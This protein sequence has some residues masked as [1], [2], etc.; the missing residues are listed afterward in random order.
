[1]VHVTRIAVDC[2]FAGTQTGLGRYSRELVSALLRRKDE[3][4]YI[5]LVHSSDEP[6]IAELPQQVETISVPAPHYSLREQWEIP[7]AIRLAQADLFF[8]LHFNVPFFCPV[9]FI[10][11]VHDLILHRYPNKASMAKKAAYRVLMARAVRQARRIISVSAFTRSELRHFYG[12]RMAAKTVVIHEGVSPLF[13]RASDADI[14]R[15]RRTYDLA[16][17]FL[18]YVGNAKQH[19]NVQML[20][21]AFEEVRNQKAEVRRELVLVTGGRER[22]GVRLAD[23]VRVIEKVAD[24]DLP[25]LY[26]AADAFVTASLYEGFGL[27]V[28]EAERC[29][30]PVIAAKRGSIPEVASP[31]ATLLEPTAQAFAAAMSRTSFLPPTPTPLL[32]EDTA[33]D[34]ARLLLGD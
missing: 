23:G 32:W 29:G 25:S 1:M 12:K 31:S 3:I 19:K 17:H 18:L 26:S 5:L 30:C 22:D 6:W 15:T 24:A 7:R 21:D 33:A 34:T 20:I 8:A 16:D 9:P 10:V 28:A 2:R 14:A 13:T 4:L 27:P 11:T